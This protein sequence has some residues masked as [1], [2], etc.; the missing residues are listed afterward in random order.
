MNFTTVN[1]TTETL[2]KSLTEQL[3]IFSASGSIVKKGAE[4]LDVDSDLRYVK[5]SLNTLRQLYEDDEALLDVSQTPLLF[6][7]R[8]VDLQQLDALVEALVQKS[9]VFTLALG[10][11]FSAICDHL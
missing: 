3:R 5:G 10:D 8:G 4:P 6:E 9:V 11:V 7:E 1:I 2:Q